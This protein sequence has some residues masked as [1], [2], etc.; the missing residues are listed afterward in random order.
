[1]LNNCTFE[2]RFLYVVGIAA[3][4]LRFAMFMLNDS[5]SCVVLSLTVLFVMQ[6]VINT[7]LSSPR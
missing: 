4:I 1:M 6:L 2:H 3:T 7:Q 5:F